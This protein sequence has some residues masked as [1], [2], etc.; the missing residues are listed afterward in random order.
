MPAAIDESNAERRDVGTDAEFRAA[1]RPHA[2]QPTE[3]RQDDALIESA[4]Q[5]HPLG[6]R[7]RSALASHPLLL[8]LPAELR[9]DRRDLEAGVVLESAD[10]AVAEHGHTETRARQAIGL[11]DG[12]QRR[13][14]QRRGRER[15]VN[16][17]AHITWFALRTFICRLQQI[18]KHLPAEVTG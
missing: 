16:I 14:T 8:E 4:E 9:H 2:D 13:L 10:D 7:R 17:A 18:Q 1:R 11:G 15:E 6:D 3:A 5:E 12:G